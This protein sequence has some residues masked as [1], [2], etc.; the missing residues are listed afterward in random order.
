MVIPPADERV[1]RPERTPQRAP[2]PGPVLM[3]EALLEASLDAALVVDDRG[4]VILVNGKAERMFGYRRADLLGARAETL[5]SWPQL[6]AHR[7]HLDAFSRGRD[8]R[9]AGVQQDGIGVRR[10]GSEFPMEVSL[11]PVI[12]DAEGHLMLAVCRDVTQKTQAR[13]EA[14]RLKRDFMATISHELRTPLTCLMG[15]GEMMEDLPDVPL[16]AQRFLEVMMRS[17]RRE[18]SVVSD[19][20][21]MTVIDSG[22]LVAHCASVDLRAIAQQAAQDAQTQAAGFG[23]TLSVEVCEAPVPV[24]GDEAK[25]L[26]AVSRLLCNSL[27]LT[28]A[29]GQVTLRALSSTEQGILD[30]IDHGPGIP[31]AEQPFVFDRLFR[32][33]ASGLGEVPGIGIGLTIAKS[34]MEAHGGTLTLRES[35]SAGSVFRLALPLSPGLI[36]LPLEESEPSSVAE[37]VIRATRANFI[38]VSAA[39]GLGH[40]Q[41]H[42]ISSACRRYLAAAISGRREEALK[43]VRESMSGQDSPLDLYVDIF[44]SALYEV[45]HRWKTAGLTI[46]EEHLATTTTQHILNVLH[47]ERQLAGSHRKTALVTGV[48]NERHVIGASIVANVLRDEGWDVRFMGTDLPHD[49]IVSAIQSSRASLVAISVT[50]SGC[51][52]GARDLIA[53]IRQSSFTPPRII[54]GGAA[55]VRDKQLWQAIGA[56]GFAADARNVAELASG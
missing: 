54:V 31:E 44:Q 29:G 46:A 47:E 8:P 33:S 53:H 41:E 17:A 5:V 7:S 1:D 15:Y 19:L 27:M 49:A 32:T 37:A 26:D 2:A 40:E 42:A 11:A 45:G 24:S 12:T 4:I 56:D 6:L 34:I 20:L 18:L 55:F 14:N 48:V 43:V 50:M 51:V 25:L 3:Y 38:G 23:V 9:D 13:A 39:D 28:P 52:E 36:H 30:V 22:D 10:D 35:S 21:T 16:E